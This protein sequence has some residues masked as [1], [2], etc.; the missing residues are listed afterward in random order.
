MKT[1]EISKSNELILT[2]EQIEKVIKLGGNSI[3][4]DMLDDNFTVNEND[5][6]KFHIYGPLGFVATV[7]RNMEIINE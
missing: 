3:V 7:N 1:L 6:K 5:C 4:G 2:I